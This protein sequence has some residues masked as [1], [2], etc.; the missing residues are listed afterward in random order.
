MSERRTEADSARRWKVCAG[1]AAVFFVATV[2]GGGVALAD[3]N[4]LIDSQTEWQAALGGGGGGGGIVEPMAPPEWSAYMS[5][6]SMFLMEGEPYPTTTVF[7][8]PT[9]PQ[10]QLYVYPGGGS[11]YPSDAGLVMVWAPTAPGE[12][13]SAWNYVYGLDPDLSNSVINVT[14]TA[15]QWGATGQ[16]RNVSFGIRDAA[17]AIRSWHWKCGPGNP[18]PWGVPTTITITPSIASVNATTPVA[19][20]F[21][22]NPAFNIVMSM[23]FIV[24]ENARWVGG[25]LPVPPPG[26]QV[27]VGLWN[28]WHNLMVTPAIQ[29]KPPL[30][31]KW[32]QPV[33]E[34]QPGLN[35][36]VFNGWD[37][38]SI[39]AS[40]TQRPIC[41]DDWQCNSNQPVTD[42]HW[43]GSFINWTQPTP[44]QLPQAFHIAIWT[45]KPA[46][47]TNPWS[48]PDR[49]VWQT[50]CTNYT[51]NFAGYDHDPRGQVQNEACFQ[52]NQVLRPEEWFH[53]DP[54][55]NIYWLSIAAIWQQTPTYPW[56]WKTRPHMFQDAAVRIT[57]VTPAWPPTIGSVWA[58]GTRVLYPTSPETPWDFAF[59]LSTE[60]PSIQEDFGDA[61][62]PTYPTLLASNGARHVIV[63]NVFLGAAIDAEG[64]GQQDPNALGDDNNGVDD[65]D[66]VVFAG[67]LVAGQPATI[68]VT[69][70]VAGAL[71][72]WVDF[73]ANGSWAEAS[74]KVF[75][76]VALSAGANALTFNVPA[77]ATPGPTFA[78]FRFSTAGGLSDTGPAPDGE[79]EDY[80]VVIKEAQLDFGDAPA[81]F[82]T[83]LA[84]NGARHVIGSGLLLGNLI[85]AEPNGIP[86]PTATGDDTTGL[87]DED[88]V[89]FN[90]ALFSGVPNTI[91]VTVTM[92]GVGLPAFLNAWI[93]FNGDGDWA[94]AGEQ[95]FVNQPV[96]SG[97]NALTF[98]PGAITA[99]G[100]TFAR[101]R[102]STQPGLTYTGPAPDGEVEDYRIGIVPVK[103]IQK[104]DLGTTG[105]DV[106]FAPAS[107]TLADDFRCTAS[108]PITD[109]HLWTSFR[110]DILP[111]LG[112]TSLTFTI[113]IYTDVPAGPNNPYSHP[114]YMLWSKTFTP[115]TYNAGLCTHVAAGEWW[116]TPP[117]FWRFPGDFRVYQYDFA[118]TETEA[119]RQ[120][121]GTIYWLVVKHQRT[122]GYWLGW[123]TSLQHW[124]DDACWLDE[125][126]GAPTWRELR[127]GDNHPMMPDSMDL[128]FA[129]TGV[130]EPV[131]TDLDFGDAPD[132]TYPTLLANNG[133]RHIIVPGFL[134]GGLIDAEANGQPDPTATG[135]DLAGVDDEDGVVFNT[136][137][138]PNVP[139]T[140]TVTATIPAGAPAY[141]N[142]W[143]D[144][145][146][147]GDWADA[148]EQI[149]TDQPVTSGA[150]AL[151]FTPGAITAVGK[152]FARFRLSSAMGLTPTGQAP[153]G[154]V[155]DYEI[156]I[157]PIKWLQRP[158]LSQYGVDV[159]NRYVQLADD[160]LCTQSGPITDFHI[161]TSFLND[162]VPEIP[163]GLTITLYLYADVPDPNPQDP[164]DWSHP[165]SLLWSKTFRPGT[166]NAGLCANV[167]G[168]EWWHEP[169]T[170]LW[171]FPGDHQVY[172]YDFYVHPDE[173]FRQREGTIYWLGM[174]YQSDLAN[175]SMGWK[176]SNY[177]WNDDACWL[178]PA[179]G[180]WRELRYGD[181]H[182]WRPDSMDLAFAV[183]GE[184]GPVPPTEDFGDAPDPTY[185]TLLGSN[186]AR[187][188][189]VPGIQLGAQIDAEADGQP[190]ANATGDDIANL[191][192]EDGVVFVGS[193]VPGATAT[194]QVTASVPGILWAWFDFGGDGSWAQAVDR[195]IPGMPIGP[196]VT[197]ISFNV[198][199]TTKS[200]LT[201]F[202]RFRFTTNSAVILGFDGPAPDGEVEDYMV[203]VEPCNRPP[204]DSDGDGDVDLVDFAAFSA[205][206]NGPNNPWAGPNPKTCACFDN[207]D[208]GDVDLVDF[209][210]F[211]A[212]FNGPNNPPAC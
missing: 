140:I 115:G 3:P 12:Y 27:P 116:H 150:N 176:S 159:S 90:T 175:F 194:V 174:K 85:D 21:M 39:Y 137:L 192:D 118:V 20:G 64:D 58:S 170:N 18:I 1:C 136:A 113:S 133:A 6:W 43:W 124:N 106:E 17:G 197:A 46:G 45:D 191:P 37:E 139:N 189:V 74:N 91:T 36:P 134:L 203:T 142:A 102:L 32:S 52:F 103:W 107:F 196:G 183:T 212:C 160:F 204:Q 130:E 120:R 44:P 157:V 165:G 4:F 7:V 171:Q 207:D 156:R 23:R 50:F 147:D 28:Y 94:D 67:P 128:A 184:A 65:E 9:L 55:Q 121:E 131:P 111:P 195:I 35:P 25:A 79:V 155:E 169:V 149:F 185:P 2:G 73:E 86:N 166:Y 15:P 75:N 178:D 16:I 72:A 80:Q 42:I 40:G 81:P 119:F 31:L 100:Q 205:C 83:L 60:P 38:R 117:A 182:P 144:L 198:P 208:D 61:P 10:G 49:L 69:A 82:P 164:T 188:T 193:I 41:A 30:Y 87:A 180:T 99:V 54:G 8:Q 78:R 88:G 211:S 63:A 108:G 122:T 114:G 66:G 62:D 158:D 199:P 151:T 95:I 71:D 123:K 181:G 92:P 163:N 11:G 76:S 14:V 101:F 59:E 153:D 93:D 202:A 190:N 53:Q 132:P 146:G 161:W 168:G 104:P 89:T 201:T 138:I 34:W 97:A 179:S 127:Y 186:G 70:S 56:G 57:A 154:E 200:G 26:S 51:W 19:S 152:T 187:H 47:G 143:L 96:V 209:A 129:I 167:P 206:F 68:T 148:G 98:T 105:V 135:D 210:A 29:Q 48:H 162:L 22:N 177:H 141:L 112:L 110:D 84:N 33:V 13:A 173:A 77:G 24:D 145:N 5:Q 109:F 172:Q 125:S 126:T